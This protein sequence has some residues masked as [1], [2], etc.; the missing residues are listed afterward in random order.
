MNQITLEFENSE[1]MDLVL[2]VAKRL[3]AHIIFPKRQGNSKLSN[4]ERI[5]LLKKQAD[6]LQV[7]TDIKEI[8]EDFT[9]S[10]LEHR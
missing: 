1:D 3:D 10:D 7:L 5:T 2:S 6:D 8:E 4:K 9:H